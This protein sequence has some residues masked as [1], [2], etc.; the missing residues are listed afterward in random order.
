MPC[1][2][3]GDE[4]TVKSHIIPRGIFRL[5][6]GWRPM[7][8]RARR[9]DNG[10]DESQSGFYDDRI[11][12]ERHEA[13]LGRFDDYAVRFCRA[14]RSQTE[15][16]AWHAKVP[17]PHP[18]LLVG[19]AAAVVWRMAASRTDLQPELMLGDH[20]KR[21]SDLLFDD[22]P[23]D[24]LLLLSRNAYQ[25]SGTLLDVTILPV[26]YTEL[27]LTFWRFVTCGIIFDL[28]LDSRPAP[29]MMAVLAANSDPEITLYED[30]PQNALRTPG[31]ARALVK[32]SLPRRS[33]R[34]R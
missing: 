27:N 23:F 18:E 4:K 17:N 24:P 16:G 32:V 8:A 3:C 29:E 26:P 34:K 12:C 5:M 14:F 33:Y 19:F 30:F 21:L 15:G 22:V 13:R 11:L 28:K 25:L 10:W 9:H 2:I 6:K 1:L 31:L 20:A 7:V